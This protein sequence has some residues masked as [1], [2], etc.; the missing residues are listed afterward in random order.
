M[1]RGERTVHCGLRK[2][3]SAA[4]RVRSAF[5]QRNGVEQYT[6]MAA[7]LRGAHSVKYNGDLTKNPVLSMMLVDCIQS[8]VCRLPVVDVHSG[9]R[10]T[11][12]AQLPAGSGR[13]EGGA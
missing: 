13:R 4:H 6:S 5:S 2:W 12:D 11:D 9:E 8:M 10:G 7:V 1:Q 3:L